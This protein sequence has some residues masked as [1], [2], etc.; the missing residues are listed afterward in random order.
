LAE[1]VAPS[2]AE[3]C[4]ADADP[5]IETLVSLTLTLS[6]ND[7]VETATDWLVS[8]GLGAAFGL[9]SATTPDAVSEILSSVY[10][11]VDVPLGDGVAVAVAVGVGPP[12]EV[13]VGVA[14]AVM[15]AVAVMDGV[16]LAVDEGVATPLPLRSTVWPL[17]LD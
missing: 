2:A 6:L 12:V 7:G 9:L 15:L 3:V 16:G 17:F 10:V 14:D 11:A 5:E 8:T 13:V 4:D 1:I